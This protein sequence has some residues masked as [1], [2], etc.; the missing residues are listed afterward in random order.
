MTVKALGCNRFLTGSARAKSLKL[1]F[2]MR[3]GTPLK[4]ES[5]IGFLNLLL[6]Y[7]SVT[8][9]MIPSLFACTYSSLPTPN[10]KQFFVSIS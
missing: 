7:W 8:Q 3:N 2:R 5:G 6:V 1:M 10:F 9:A 4:I